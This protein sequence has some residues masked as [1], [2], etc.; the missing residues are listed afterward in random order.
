MATVIK[1]MAATSTF[2]VVYMIAFVA[3]AYLFHAEHW[4]FF[5][6]FIPAFASMCAV[7]DCCEEKPK[8]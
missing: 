4:T 7:V 8:H 5:I 3:I 6:A 2:L 1:T